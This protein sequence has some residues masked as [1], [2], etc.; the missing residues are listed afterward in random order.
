MIAG[1]FCSSLV[2]EKDLQTA[3]LPRLQRYVWR[4]V[5]HTMPQG[6]AFFLTALIV[7]LLIVNGLIVLLRW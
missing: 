3:M 2:D 6:P 5:D 4:I 1:R 7:L